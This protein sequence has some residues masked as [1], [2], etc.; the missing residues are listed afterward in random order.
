MVV[1]AVA[2]AILLPAT[3]LTGGVAA[4]SSSGDALVVGA[5]HTDY[6]TAEDA[7]ASTTNLNVDD[8]LQYG[9]YN[10]S[11][12][13]RWTLNEGSGSAATDDINSLTASITGASWTAGVEGQAL[14]FD[15][16]DDYAQVSSDPAV[17]VGGQS[18]WTATAW[19]NPDNTSGT[20]DIL[21]FGNF[22]AG[23]AVQDGSYQFFFDDGSNF[24]VAED[25]ASSDSGW[26]HVAGVYNG[27]HIALY[28][29]GTLVEATA[30]SGPVATQ[31]TD[32]TIGALDGTDRFLDGRIDEPRVY[33]AAL[34][35]SQISDLASSGD[36]T[37]P[38][39]GR[40]VS[41]NHSVTNPEQLTVN[42]NPPVNA[43]M[44][45][46]GEYWTGSGWA[47]DNSTTTSSGGN[48]SIALDA[49]ADTWRVVV[50]F[51]NE[52]GGTVVQQTADYIL[53]TNHKPQ[54][55]NASPTGD[56]QSSDPTFTLDVTDPEFGTAQGD[57]V[58]ATLHVDGSSVGSDT[59]TSN[60]TAS[61][62]P[63][64]EL[65]GGN[66]S[67]YWTLEDEYGASTT[68]QTYNIS[69]PS[70]LYIR[71]ETN[72]SE[73]VD[74]AT[75]NITYYAGDEIIRKNTSDGSI[76]LSGLPIDETIIALAKAPGYHTRTIVI[77]DIYDQ[78]SLYLLNESLSSH[79]LVF[80]V[81]DPTGQ[82]PRAETVLMVQRDIKLNGTVEWRTVAGDVFGA[83]GVVTDLEAGDRYR[84]VIRNLE[85][86]DRTVLG[87]FTPT[88]SQRVTL[89]PASAIVS[90]N[91]SSDTAIGFD[92]TRNENGSAIIVEYSDP[93]QST[94]DLDFR[95]VERWNNSNVLLGNQSFNDLG[96]LTY[97]QALSESEQNKSWVVEFYWTLDDDR[98]GRAIAPVG[99][100]ARDIIPDSLDS[101]IR[102]SAGVCVL[103]ITSLVF[104]EL[105]VGVGAVTTALV[106]AL[107]WYTGFLAGVTS[108][109]AVVLAIG[110]GLLINYNSGSGVVG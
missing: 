103:F 21:H 49:T 60:G 34:S 73:L 11:I 94:A 19:V 65:D 3:P 77:T 47:L 17:D 56:L 12:S 46:R 71:S 80:D 58:T 37:A 53:F 23:L 32:L 50:E 99:Q 44:T 85:T 92:A 16:S 51:T 10:D 91:A 106:G 22:D 67:Y 8:V 43:S 61:V 100:G 28:L 24:Y 35:D 110:V 68:T 15:G 89:E 98:Q 74:T 57:T 101:V 87:A 76:D 42:F 75:V 72:P 105:N 82:Y 59:L 18:A 78:N 88:S 30:V 38:G 20:T 70:T 107:L 90:V 41:Q 52:P 25:P 40:Y 104:S 31:D 66:H 64:V 39:P 9:P 48:Q 86:G 102:V 84:L 109:P 45:I 1:F 27:S 79:E 69:T 7:P 14:D 33:M 54:G 36:A 55:S 13:A 81:S 62:N 96:N 5:Q 6:A 63:S 83:Q 4:A 95:I 108:G 26:H 2:F 93:D 97:D 29:D